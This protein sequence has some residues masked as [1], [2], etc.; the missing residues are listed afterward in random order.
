MTEKNSTNPAGLMKSAYTAKA[1]ELSLRLHHLKNV[2]CLAAFAAE[3]RRVLDGTE[4]ALSHHPDLR[5][6]ISGSIDAPNNWMQQPDV[7]G[8]VLEWL[9]M[10]M[11]DLNIEMSE[12]MYAMAKGEAL[13]TKA[14]TMSA[15]GDPIVQTSCLSKTVFGHA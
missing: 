11:D 1:D 7:S 4:N 14:A 9:S 6:T 2:A 15:L 8:D 13:I 3:A 12:T 5:E 10:Q